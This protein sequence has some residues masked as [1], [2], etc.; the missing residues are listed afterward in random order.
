MPGTEPESVRIYK[1]TLQ[2][3]G[4]GSWIRERFTGSP[5]KTLAERLL[6]MNRW[7]RVGAAAFV[8]ILLSSSLACPPV[9]LARDIFVDNSLGDDRQ[10]GGS[11]ESGIGMDGPC[12]SIARALFLAR[13]GDRIILAKT[14][15]PYRESLTLQGGRHS[16]IGT[17]PF[18]LL[19]NGA[20]LDG[21]QPIRPAAWKSFRRDIYCFQPARQ[22]LGMLYVEDRPAYPRRRPCAETTPFNLAGG[23][24]CL[25][26]GWYYF[27]AEPGRMPSQYELSAPALSVGLT[28][29]D[30][31]DVVIEDL[32]IQGFQQ[33]GVC[34]ADGTTRTRFVGLTTRG[35]G[36]SG[37]AVTGAS[38]VDIEACL[39]GNNGVAQVWLE[40]ETTVRIQNCTLPD[41]SAPAIVRDGGRLVE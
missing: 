1:K 8:G 19:G 32:V 26:G 37:I 7:Q 6:S 5:Q 16:G 15:E 21:R 29:Y 18:R 38:R 30:V 34:A 3:D 2:G 14:T 40:G 10:R 12:R 11:A 25:F 24:G 35:N 41:G 28:L 9:G 39:S 36:R 4:P 17:H 33:D 13:A 23:E 22:S 31:R 27:R 20:T